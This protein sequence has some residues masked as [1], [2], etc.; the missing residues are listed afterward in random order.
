MLIHAT[1][2][3]GNERDGGEDAL[4]NK[5]AACD[6]FGIPF[7]AV[8]NQPAIIRELSNETSRGD[9]VAKVGCY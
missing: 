5:D 1:K 8:V 3:P 4:G 7:L 9:T 6:I 2:L